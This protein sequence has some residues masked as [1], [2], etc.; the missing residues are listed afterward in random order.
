MRDGL[1]R[2]GA[3]VIHAGYIP[4]A[5][6]DVESHHVSAG[7]FHWTCLYNHNGNTG[8]HL[9][10]HRDLQ[11]AQKFDWSVS[12]VCGRKI[13]GN[14]GGLL[15]RAG[16]GIGFMVVAGDWFMAWQAKENPLSTQLGA[17]LYAAP[18]ML[19]LVIFML[20]KESSS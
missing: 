13:L 1:K 12:V 18:N 9:C 5:R 7:A 2:S 3:T 19:A 8:G 15:C 20:H 4:C 14:A 6:D 17:F 11:D 16:V 10:L